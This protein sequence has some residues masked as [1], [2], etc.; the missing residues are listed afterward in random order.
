MHE[1]REKNKTLWNINV[2]QIKIQK[3]PFQKRIIAKPISN[4]LLK[5]LVFIKSEVNS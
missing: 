3:F 2:I 5:T 1:K 4:P